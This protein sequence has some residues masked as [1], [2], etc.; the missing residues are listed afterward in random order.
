MY[1]CSCCVLQK[2]FSASPNRGRRL[3]ALRDTCWMSAA[4]SGQ[5]RRRLKKGNVRKKQCR[6]GCD[7]DVCASVGEVRMR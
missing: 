4:E 6:Q 2:A 3:S 1:T 5:A 7:N